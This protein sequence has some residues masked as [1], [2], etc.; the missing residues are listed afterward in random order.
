MDFFK[1]VCARYVP[2]A[3]ACWLGA[4]PNGFPGGGMPMAPSA[5]VNPIGPMGPA[6]PVTPPDGP[7]GPVSPG[8]PRGP[9]GPVR[10]VQMALIC[11]D[12]LV[13]GKS[14]T[15]ASTC[16]V[17]FRL[18]N[19][20]AAIFTVVVSVRVIVALPAKQRLYPAAP[21]VSPYT[22]VALYS[23]TPNVAGG[24]GAALC[25]GQTFLCPR[26]LHTRVDGLG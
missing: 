26:H 20:L 18:L 21:C 19:A 5:P 11:V 24:G 12:T 6:G 22:A 9:V 3:H 4:I 23:F 10:P 1:T 8:K 25:R 17:P 14:S 13:L 16:G 2:T 15:P 7:I